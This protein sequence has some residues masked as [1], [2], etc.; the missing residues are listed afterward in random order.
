MK[1]KLSLC[2]TSELKKK[3][4]QLTFHHTKKKTN[5]S[6]ST[7]AYFK[8]LLNENEK[9]PRKFW[10]TLKKI[11]PVKSWDGGHAKIFN[12]DGELTILQKY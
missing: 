5:R 10:K 8:N 1:G 9:L 12:I 3:N 4:H 11:Y 7:S 6:K 2:L